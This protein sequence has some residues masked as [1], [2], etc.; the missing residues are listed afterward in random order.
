MAERI[1]CG[2]MMPDYTLKDNR[3][4]EFKISDY[5]GKKLLLSFHPLAFTS[6]CTLQMKSLEDHKDEFKQL[7]TVVVGVSIDPVPAKNAWAKEMGVK[8]TPLLADN[9]P[10]GELARM[11]GLFREG[12]GFSERA[13]VVVDEKG[14]V[15]FVKVYDI[16]VVPDIQEIL[17]FLKKA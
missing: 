7:N 5:R 12:E 2:D 17:D 11:L 4:K 14:K 10:H 1:K 6:V 13:N 16:P 15:I 8:D 3:N 9:W